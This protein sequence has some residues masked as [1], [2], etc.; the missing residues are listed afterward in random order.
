MNTEIQTIKNDKT[1]A[2]VAAA[3]MQ[4][5]RIESAYT[6]A[7]HR[8]RSIDQVRQNILKHC[9]RPRFAEKVQYS[10]PVGGGSVKGPT[11]RFA[12][13]AI[14]EMT[15]VFSDIQVIF[16]DENK[17]QIKIILCD[18]ETNCQFTKEITLN[19]TVERKNKKGREVIGERQ[20]T[21]NQTVYIVKATEDELL[22]K[23]AALISKAIRNEGLRLIPQ[24]IIEEAMDVAIHTMR[25]ADKEDPDAAKNRIIDAFFKIGVK[26]SDLVAFLGH[27]IDMIT[28]KELEELRGMH[29]A[30]KEG[31]AKW[32]DFIEEPTDIA[33]AKGKVED[34]KKAEK[35]EK[36]E[37]L[38]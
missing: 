4:K 14:R 2:A 29:S 8:P 32:S 24:D 20:N 27:D 18:L 13:M 7:M 11:I 33:K 12:E 3:E 15:N 34:M 10:K 19:K 21:Y 16:E 1:P 35:T 30:L 17:K 25:K 5:A 38:P 23:E 26:V 36:E 6:I 28:A 9:E 37:P 22:N 31:S